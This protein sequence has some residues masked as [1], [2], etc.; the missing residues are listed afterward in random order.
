[1][2][3]IEDGGV[4]DID[5]GN[6]DDLMGQT[7]ILGSP[8]VFRKDI[9]YRSRLTFVGGNFNSC[10]MLLTFSKKQEYLKSR[11]TR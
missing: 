5:G 10:T 11:K 3:D 7:M 6:C 9:V 1:M 4:G 8:R 2:L